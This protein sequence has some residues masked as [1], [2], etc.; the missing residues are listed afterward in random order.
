MFHNQIYIILRL[1]TY[2]TKN[3]IGFNYHLKVCSSLFQLKR[4]PK[5]GTDYKYKK[6]KIEA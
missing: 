3:K 5:L 2:I 6:S 4:D 1:K